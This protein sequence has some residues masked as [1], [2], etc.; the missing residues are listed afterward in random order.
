MFNQLW[1]CLRLSAPFPRPRARVSQSWLCP[2][3]VK[4]ALSLHVFHPIF[5]QSLIVSQTHTIWCNYCICN[6]EISPD[7]M[8]VLHFSTIIL[9]QS[10]CVWIYLEIKLLLSACTDSKWWKTL[11][12]HLIITSQPGRALV[13]NAPHTCLQHVARPS[14]P[15]NLHEP[16]DKPFPRSTRGTPNTKPDRIFLSGSVLNVHESRNPRANYSAG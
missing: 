11:H 6:H 14:I 7:F 13:C 10:G 8:H 15:P 1:W 9:Q 16:H 2:P 12:N 4:T 3:G 5:S